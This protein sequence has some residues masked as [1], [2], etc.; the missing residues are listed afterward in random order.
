V[1]LKANV[2]AAVIESP[3]VD[4]VVVARRTTEGPADGP[5]MLPGRDHW[6]D[7]LLNGADDAA[8]GPPSDRCEPEHM[9]AE[10]LLFILYTSGTTAAPKGIMHT[11]GGYLTQV[12][13][14]HRVV[15]DL[16]PQQDVY[17]CAADIGWVTGHSYIVYGPLAN[18]ATSVLYEGTPD[19]P[20]RDRWWSIIERYGVTILYTAPTAIRTF[21]KWGTQYPER[22]DLTSLRVL[23]SVGEPINPE[24]WMWYSTHIGGGSCP[25]VDTWWQTETGGIMIAPLPGITA[26]KPG[27]ATFPLPGIAAEVVDERGARVDKGGGYLTLTEPW[28]AMT[29]GIYGDPDRYRET[30]WSRFEGRYFAGDGA[31]VD[32]DGYFWLLGRV[33]DVMNVSGHRISTTEVESALVDHPAV[34]ESAVV[35]ASDPTSGQAIV[36]FVTLRADAGEPN[37]ERGQ[38]LRAHVAAKIGPIARPRTII[39]TDEL[40]KTRSG[41]IMRRLL[42]D[43]AEGRRL[44]DTTT[45]ADPAVVDEIRR[46]AAISPTDE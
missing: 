45:L 40:P 7:D 39:F 43:V 26:T 2:D 38:E 6:W 36:A 12:A 34:A 22:H 23:G 17:W 32:E 5:A 25:V 15:F 1:A 46:L 35:G 29:R 9:D 20:D 44:G 27:S 4:H 16:H 11:T 24:A 8:G 30:Y 19:F 37:D 14:T 41:K 33:D 31:K 3:C 13:Y 42:G 18:G 28:P 10:D 21:M